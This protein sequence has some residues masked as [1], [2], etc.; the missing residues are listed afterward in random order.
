LTTFD[1][2]EINPL[3]GTNFPDWF[4][5]AVFD[6][7]LP[8]ALIVVAIAQLVV[9]LASYHVDRTLTHLVARFLSCWL[10]QT[11]LKFQT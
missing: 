1:S 7:G 3:T 2:L 10:Q 11:L 8:G 5:L 9:G 4:K 6:T